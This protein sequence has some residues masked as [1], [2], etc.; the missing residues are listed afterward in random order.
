MSPSEEHVAPE[1]VQ[2]PPWQLP[3]Q[4]WPLLVQTMPRV[5]QPPLTRGWHFPR[6]QVLLQHSPST[7]HACSVVL[8]TAAPHLPPTQ[9]PLQQAVE[10]VHTPPA[11]VQSP[12]LM[13]QAF[14]TV[15][16]EPEQ[17]PLSA[18]QA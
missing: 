10:I 11:V 4:H 5:V 1:P 14:A 18:R 13:A 16:H 2:R 6:V 7:V 9:V 12:W 8:H 15:S 17:Q 3:E